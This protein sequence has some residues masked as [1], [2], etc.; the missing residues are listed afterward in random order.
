MYLLS[1]PV[2]TGR[3]SR[4]P[5]HQCRSEYWHPTALSEADAAAFHGALC[6][7]VAATLL[8]VEIYL[9]HVVGAANLA[10]CARRVPIPPALEADSVLARKQRW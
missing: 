10:A 9:A 2:V 1:M 4:G 5:R 7:I 3:P 6:D 8:T